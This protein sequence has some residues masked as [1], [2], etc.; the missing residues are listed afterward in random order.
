MKFDDEHVFA[1][2]PATLLKMFTDRAYFEKKY[3]ALPGISDF[4]VLECET[5]GTRFHITHRSSQKADIPLQEFGKKFVSDSMVVTQTDSW[6]TATGV[7]RLDVAVKGMPMKIS[8]GMKVETRGKGSVNRFQWTVSSGI[9]LIGGKLEKVLVEDI[10]TK[11]V[12]DLAE[13]TKL[14]K[15]Y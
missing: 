12:A 4:T 6:D 11:S 15:N 8:C 2:P 1:K 5:S 14:L 7:G 13:S 3:A 9:P 10:K